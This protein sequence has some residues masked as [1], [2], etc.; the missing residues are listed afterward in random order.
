M[1]T[2]LI[3]NTFRVDPFGPRSRPLLFTKLSLFLTREPILMMSHATSSWRIR[4]AWRYKQQVLTSESKSIIQK[5][6]KT[7]VIC[8][9]VYFKYTFSYNYRIIWVEGIFK[10]HLVQLPCNEQRHLQVKLLSAP[11]SL[12]FSI[13]WD[14]ASTTSLGNLFQCFTTTTWKTHTLKTY[15]FISTTLLAT[16]LFKWNTSCQKFY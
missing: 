7:D 11:S 15:Y 8:R 2:V 1:V 13:S 14:G 16:N 5:S 10:G 9:Y 6:W 3:R 4:T 12:T